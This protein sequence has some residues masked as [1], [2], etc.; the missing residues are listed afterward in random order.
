MDRDR[1][2][3]DRRR[4]DVLAVLAAVSAL[5]AVLAALWPDWIEAFGLDP[6]HGSGLVEWLIPAA[7]ALTAVLLAVASRAR[8]RAWRA[9]RE[10][11]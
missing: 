4:R 11:G 8:S 6:D 3:P 5:L 2:S 9:D 1:V 7:L 10:T